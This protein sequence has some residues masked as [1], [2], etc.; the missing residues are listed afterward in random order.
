MLNGFFPENAFSTQIAMLKQG[1]GIE[2]MLMSQWLEQMDFSSRERQSRGF[3]PRLLKGFTNSECVLAM[4]GIVAAFGVVTAAVAESTV[5]SIAAPAPLSTVAVTLNEPA[6]PLT[7]GYHVVKATAHVGRETLPFAC[8]IFLPA[9][10][11]K[12]AG[13]LPVV[14]TLHTRGNSGA[15][16]GGGLLGEGLGLMLSGNVDPRGTGD[17]PKSP[18]HLPADAAFIGIIPQC[19]AAHG[20]DETPVP[21]ILSAFIG[22]VARKYRADED[23]VYLTGFSYGGSSTWNIA[24]QTPERFAA[25][26]PLDGRATHNPAADVKKLKDVSIYISVGEDDADFIPEAQ[27]MRDALQAAGHAHFTYHLVHGGNHWGYGAVYTDPEFWK[28]LFAQ[29]RHPATATTLPAS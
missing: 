6:A 29:R 19:P 20:W 15:D 26:A 10:Y 21:Q 4:L 16:G 18:L 22:E 13:R 3:R 14:V 24:V 5:G 17:K 11:F 7:A 8:G 12:S 28:W 25:I 1:G 2:A 9:S 27:R 23:R